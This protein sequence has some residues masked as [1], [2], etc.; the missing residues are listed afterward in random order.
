[1]VEIVKQPEDMVII[2]IDDVNCVGVISAVNV[3]SLSVS[4]FD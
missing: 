4:K 2:E 3:D 1:M